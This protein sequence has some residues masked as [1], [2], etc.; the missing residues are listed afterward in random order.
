MAK[1]RPYQ[2]LLVWKL[3][4]DLCIEVY[5]LVRSFPT[6]ERFALSNQMRRSAYAVPMNL[7]TGNVKR[8]AKEKL[9]SVSYAASA[10]EELEYQLM[11]CHDLDY[12][13]KEDLEQFQSSIRRIGFLLSRFRSG[14]QERGDKIAEKGKPSPALARK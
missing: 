9:Q 12:V 2:E 1:A 14:V 10:L 11:L 4:H 3:A 5:Q 8:S 7:V 13:S 6:H